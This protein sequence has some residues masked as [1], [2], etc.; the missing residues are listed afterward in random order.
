MKKLYG[1][2]LRVPGL[3]WW[4]SGYELALQCRGTG[5]VPGVGRLPTQQDN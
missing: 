4:P 1:E 3:P 2:W 5:L